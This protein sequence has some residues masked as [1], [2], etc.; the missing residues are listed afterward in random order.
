MATIFA[1]L[2][3]FGLNRDQH[4]DHD[5]GGRPSFDTFEADSLLNYELVLYLD[6]D[7]F[8]VRDPSSLFEDYFAAVN[9]QAIKIN[10]NPTPAVPASTPGSKRTSSKR[11]TPVPSPSTPSSPDFV[12]A[13]YAERLMASSPR[14]EF[15]AGVLLI[16]PS[17]HLF[18]QMLSLARY[19]GS[20]QNRGD[21]GLLQR[22]FFYS[23][24]ENKT[25]GLEDLPRLE[26]LYPDHAISGWKDLEERVKNP[27][28]CDKD[29]VIR[30]PNTQNP[31]VRGKKLW[32]GPVDYRGQHIVGCKRTL[33]QAQTLSSNRTGIVTTET[34]TGAEEGEGEE[35]P[36]IETS[37]YVL[38]PKLF[39]LQKRDQRMGA[40]EVAYTRSRFPEARVLTSSACWSLPDIYN[41]WIGKWKLP[42]LITTCRIF[43]VL[44]SYPFFLP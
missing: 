11:P 2:H 1:K 31:E 10:T 6:A 36:V 41:L 24:V 32:N 16:K 34:E 37:M 19:I 7:T 44:L 25:V 38:V 9:S 26:R 17:L 33:L 27:L 28:L 30:D 15:N 22:Y 4:Q 18:D 3:I 8:A 5:H 23:C 42:S 39:P 12:L 21:Q 43:K 40:D 20:N 13:A 35:K 29:A 14:W